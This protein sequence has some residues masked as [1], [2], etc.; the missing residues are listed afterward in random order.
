[1]SSF[2]QTWAS[3]IA[4][5]TIASL[6]FTWY[7]LLSVHVPDPYLDEIF[8]VPQAQRYCNNDWRWDPKITTPPGLYLISW[9]LH[10]TTGGTIDCDTSTLRM[11]NVGAICAIHLLAYDTLRNL[12]CQRAFP[13]AQNGGKNEVLHQ[14]GAKNPMS[15]LDTHTALNISLF[16]PLFFFAALYYTDVVS[17][18]IVLLSYNV[19]LKRN[20]HASRIRRDITAISV[21]TTALLFRQTNIFWIAV[22]PA[23][24]AVVEA[25]KDE[26]QSGHTL[27]GDPKPTLNEI[28]NTNLIHD[29]SSW[30]AG[31]E[32]YF[33]FFLSIGLA[34]LKRPLLV[35]RVALPYLTL[36]VIFAAFVIWNGGVVLGDK[37]NHVAML[38]VPQMLY[39][40]PYIAFFSFP[41]LVV[42][43]LGPIVH[44]LPDGQFKDLC[45]NTLV[46]KS[47]L[48]IPRPLSTMSFV[49]LGLIAVH[50]NTFIHPFTLADNR[51]YVFYVFRILQRHWVIK[52]LA[53]P[54][55]C[56]CAWTSITTLGFGPQNDAEHKRS[57]DKARVA[58]SEAGDQPCQI[59]FIVVWLATTTLTLVSAPLVE[60]RYFIIP[61]LFW[62]LHVPYV[63]VS[64]TSRS[65]KK[66]SYDMRLVLETMW[67]LAVNALLGYNFLYRGFRWPNEPGTIQRFLF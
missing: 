13:P 17:T 67:L 27:S 21:G 34:V 64:P 29:C 63:L 66:S 30:D 42:S 52:Y 5:P 8:H 36:L 10:R 11:V 25:L 40:W 6:A 24:L 46:G 28:W 37:S 59:S 44:Q 26:S 2:L 20:K 48:T 32:D 41:L 47:K 65:T 31:V 54:F 23:G 3:S 22:F 12:R 53:V 50:Y 39:I 15:L 33:F 60:P 56:I 57:N 55:Y 58:R 4:L 19:F 35:V 61:W 16:P 18:L 14:S 1:M 43:F 38:H 51:H 45:R 7:K 62:R 49:G 9:L